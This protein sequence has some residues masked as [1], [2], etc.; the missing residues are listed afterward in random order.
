ME[1]NETK[2]VQCLVLKTSAWSW[3]RFAQVHVRRHGSFLTGSYK[4]FISI[5]T[6]TLVPRWQLRVSRIVI[7]CPHARFQLHSCILGCENADAHTQLSHDRSHLLV[8][9]CWKSGLLAF[10]DHF[11]RVSEVYASM[12]HLLTI[13]WTIR[14]RHAVD[15]MFSCW[16]P[17]QSNIA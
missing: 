12:R 7:G 9:V 14:L 3:K 5:L 17:D 6:K 16:P 10:Y 15:R 2:P 4:M 8:Y 1:R 13:I 11:S